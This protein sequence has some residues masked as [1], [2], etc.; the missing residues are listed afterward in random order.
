MGNLFTNIVTNFDYVRFQKSCPDDKYFFEIEIEEFDLNVIKEKLELLALNN[1][2]SF[3]DKNVYYV[4][5]VLEHINKQETT[6]MLQQ[7]N[8]YLFK[9]YYNAPLLAIRNIN[10]RKYQ[11]KNGIDVSEKCGYYYCCNLSNVFTDYNWF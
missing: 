11:I 10:A 9:K 3:G 7:I 8:G 5:M 2:S 4:M 6:E 1:N